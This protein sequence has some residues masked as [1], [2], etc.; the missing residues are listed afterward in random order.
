[1]NTFLGYLAK[2][3]T[4]G[5]SVIL[6]FYIT[7]MTNKIVLQIFSSGGGF[8]G[9]GQRFLEAGSGRGFLDTPINVFVLR[10]L[11]GNKIMHI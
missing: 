9:R 7:E 6:S 2:K 4:L 1:M 11:T 5:V 3:C 8:Q 10:Y